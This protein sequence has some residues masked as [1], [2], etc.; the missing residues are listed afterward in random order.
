MKREYIFILVVVFI[1]LFLRL[2]HLPESLNL[3]SDQ[4]FGILEM[5]RLWETKQVTLIGPASS[6]TTSGQYIYASSLV[7]YLSILVL[8]ISGWNPLALSY[9]LIFLQLLSF[10]LVYRML[11]HQFPSSSLPHFFALLYVF[12]PVMVNYSRFSWAP[13]YLIP[14]SS[15][16]LILLLKLTQEA[17]PS[18]FLPTLIGFSLGIGLQFHYS[19][20]L[21]V[22]LAFIWLFVA[23]KMGFFILTGTLLGL[24]IGFSPI[25]LFEVRHDFHN[26]RALLLF[27]QT[28]G[29]EGSLGLGIVQPHYFLSLFPFLFFF[30]S[31]V[32]VFFHKKSIY[33]SGTIIGV[34]ILFSLSSI[35]PTPSEGFT[36]PSGWNYPGLLHARDIILSQHKKEYNVIDVLSGDTRA[37]ALR[38]LLVLS[39]YPPMDVAAYP[40]SKALFLYTR[41]PIDTILSGSLWEIDVV[42]PLRVSNKWH[43][44]NGIFLYLLEKE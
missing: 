43:I 35:L 26:F 17:K 31:Y 38:S 29:S 10:L 12:S 32:L 4:G 27:F 37:Y 36:M 13:N 20:F 1:F 25:I 40:S 15:I 16:I 8:V 21:I 9:F 34:Y 23:Q 22:L 33:L 19:F 41:E 3:G 39:G 42:K 6:L 14:V 28:T 5:K 44:Q 24:I 11:T 7:Y 30:L 2:F 18:F